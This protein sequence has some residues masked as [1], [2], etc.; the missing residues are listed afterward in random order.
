MVASANG[1]EMKEIGVAVVEEGPS[2]ARLYG[3]KFL[4][5]SKNLVVITRNS[6]DG[7]NL[8]KPFPR[9]G[10]SYWLNLGCYQIG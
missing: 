8:P 1:G 2:D 5:K 10:I 3:S 6:R 9:W 7:G 4:F